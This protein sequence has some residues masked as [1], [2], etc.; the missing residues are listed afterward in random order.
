[1]KACTQCQMRYPDDAGQHCFVDGAE[2]VVTT[3]PRIGST[4]AGRYVI[5]DN[6]GEGGMATVYRARH[7][8]ID[9]PCAIKIMNPMLAKDKVVR[10][11][12]RREAKSAQA[13]A[14]P[15]IIE[16]FDQGDTEDGTAY[17]V[18]ELLKGSALADVV[19]KG[20]LPLSRAIPIM[21]QMSRGI[22]RAHDLGVIHRDLKPENIFIVHRDEGGDLVKLLDFGIARSRSDSRLTNAG[23]LFGTPQYMAPER[24]TSG[25]AGPNVDLYALGVIFFELVTGR[26]PFDAPDVT[27]FLIKHIKE[28]PIAPRTMVPDLP[29]ELDAL[30]LALLAKDPKERPVDAHRIEADLTALARKLKIPLPIEVEDDPLSSRPPAKT[31]PNVAVHQWAKRVF[32]FEQMLSHAFGPTQPAEMKRTLEQLKDLVTKVTDLRATHV[33]E[34]RALEEIDKRGREGRQRFGFAVDALGVD[35]SKAKDEVRNVLARGD[36]LKEK[37]VETQA[38]Y[39]TAQ[40]ELVTWEGRSALREPSKYLA[41]A[42]RDCAEAVDLWSTARNAD[43]AS[44]DAHAEAERVASD[45]EFQIRE[46]RTALANHEKAIDTEHAAREK[47]IITMNQEVEQ[48]EATLLHLATKFCEPLRKRPELGPLFQQLESAPS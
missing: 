37:V 7:K 23:E 20:A 48:M 15:N 2:L 22:A 17:I 11:R 27:S 41:R 19:G 47:K 39:A 5:E 30:I 26:L 31:L 46:L 10:E 36:A 1:M 25:D 45:L 40:R 9:R 24:I 8:L 3:D 32:V 21:I 35:A 14:H 6:I 44:A 4:I 33:S 28:A 18:M 43:L 13:L 16:I 34:Q 38:R 29:A 42:Y 12:F